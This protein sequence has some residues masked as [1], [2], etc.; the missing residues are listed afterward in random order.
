MDDLSTRLVGFWLG[1]QERNSDQITLAF[2]GALAAKPLLW[3]GQTA[4]V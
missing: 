2:T 3:E 4:P 1:E